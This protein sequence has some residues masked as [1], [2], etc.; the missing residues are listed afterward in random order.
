RDTRP[1]YFMVGEWPG[2][3]TRTLMNLETGINEQISTENL[4]NF[5]LTTSIIRL[6]NERMQL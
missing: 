2:Q 3:G 5:R 4:E 1:E 6:V